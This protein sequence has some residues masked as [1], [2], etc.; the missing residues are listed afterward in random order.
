MNKD[1]T[2]ILLLLFIDYILGIHIQFERS[3]KSF[4]STKNILISNKKNK[5][6]K[7][8]LFLKMNDLII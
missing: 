4:I 8:K 7:F 6:K 3:N 2:L 1:F 5:N